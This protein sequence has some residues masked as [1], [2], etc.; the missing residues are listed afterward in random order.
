MHA[1]MFEKKRLMVGGAA[2]V[3]LFFVICVVFNGGGHANQQKN[4]QV[5]FD[6]AAKDLDDAARPIV[7]FNSKAVQVESTDAR[8]L[9]NARYNRYLCR[10]RH[11]VVE[12]DLSQW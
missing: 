1:P 4:D 9:K 11:I 7:D 2:I 12:C 6:R 8:K 5:R 10:F 3:V